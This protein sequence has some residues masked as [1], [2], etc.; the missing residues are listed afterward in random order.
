MDCIQLSTIPFL[1]PDCIRILLVLSQLTLLVFVFRNW[2]TPGFWLLGAGLL[3][4]LTVILFNGGL[5]PITPETVR[6]LR[7][8]APE[9][10]GQIGQR[11]GYGKDIVL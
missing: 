8:D 4:N 7:P 10:Y 5:M 11:L 2:K 9:N 6:W 1:L 3:L